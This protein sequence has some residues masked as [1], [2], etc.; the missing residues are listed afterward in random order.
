MLPQ[1]LRGLYSIMRLPCSGSLVNLTS[2]PLATINVAYLERT[3]NL[4][5]QLGVLYLNHAVR[6]AERPQCTQRPEGSAPG[7]IGVAQEGSLQ[8]RRVSG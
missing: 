6:S 3:T 7:Y 1:G 4:M 8:S 2:Q 5:Q